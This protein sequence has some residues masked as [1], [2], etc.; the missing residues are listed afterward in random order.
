[1]T[2]AQYCSFVTRIRRKSAPVPNTNTAAAAAASTF[3]VTSYQGTHIYTSCISLSRKLYQTIYRVFS[4]YG[5]LT[6]SPFLG[7]FQNLHVMCCQ[8][9]WKSQIAENDWVNAYCLSFSLFLVTIKGGW[10]SKS[11]SSVTSHNNVLNSEINSHV[12][13]CTATAIQFLVWQCHLIMCNVMQITAAQCSVSLQ[14]FL[15]MLL[16][17][18]WA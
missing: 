15:C 3:T 14:T 2:V 10:G 9:D 6:K 1:M 13:S 5:I 8:I 17:A 12:L 16:V 11:E 4:I 7:N 18:Y